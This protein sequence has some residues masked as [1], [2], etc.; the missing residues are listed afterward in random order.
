[1][2]KINHHRKSTTIYQPKGDL[3][4]VSSIQYDEQRIGMIGFG[5]RRNLIERLQSRRAK[6]LAS[7]AL[8]TRQ[9][10][11]TMYDQYKRTT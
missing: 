5:S 6:R 2:R 3:F 4:E 11:G 9:H 8:I 10:Q 1:M 7:F